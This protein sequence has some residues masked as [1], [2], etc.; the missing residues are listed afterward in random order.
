V[1]SFFRVED[2]PLRIFE[3]RY[4]Q[5]I[6][7]A[8]TD[9]TT[10]VIPFVINQEVQEFGCEVQLKD[11]VAENPGGRM[12][13]SV[14]SV[15]LVQIIS[16][17]KQL[18]GKLYAGGAIKRLP[19]SDPVESQELIRLIENYSD[20]FD[21]DFPSCVDHSVLT[22]QEVMKAL[23]LSSDEKYKFVCMSDGQYKENYLV[24]QIRYLKMIRSQEALLGNDFGLN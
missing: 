14:E 24:R 20:Q 10:F 19:C 8:R 16:F 2:I 13:I 9:N 18:E 11:V 22:R 3:P 5:L 1:F 4:K 17:S 21:K 15:A 6:E 7:D 23:N 12:V